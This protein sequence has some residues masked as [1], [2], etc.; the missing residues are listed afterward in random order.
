MPEIPKSEKRVKVNPQTIQSPGYQKASAQPNQEMNQ[1]FTGIEN[2]ISE[3]Y[4][5]ARQIAHEWHSPAVTAFRSRIMQEAA[6]SKEESQGGPVSPF[7]GTEAFVKEQREMGKSEE[8]IQAEMGGLE[9][10]FLEPTSAA[11]G[12][13]AGMGA[14]SLRAGSRSRLRTEARQMPSTS[15]PP[16]QTSQPM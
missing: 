11:A 6:G 1:V 9:E 13:F 12:G 16:S 3:N 10:P 15:Q 14:I 5:Q 2:D 8:D 4:L 7:K